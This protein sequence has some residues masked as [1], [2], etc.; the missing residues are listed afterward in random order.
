MLQ[1]MKRKLAR[2]VTRRTGIDSRHGMQGQFSLD[3]GGAR[4]NEY[5]AFK[6]RSNVPK[7]LQTV[8]Q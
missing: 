7:Y 1:K 2:Q 8:H 5:L 6:V 4:P 3:L